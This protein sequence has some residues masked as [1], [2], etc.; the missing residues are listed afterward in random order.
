[1]QHCFPHK[2][3][4]KKLYYEEG[5]KN[6]LTNHELEYTFEPIN[7]LLENKCVTGAH[8]NLAPFIS[9]LVYLDY[10]KEKSSES[11][12]VVA[13]MTSNLRVNKI[14]NTLMKISKNESY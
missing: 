10:L 14:N 3:E 4:F 11:A 8:Y 12:Y 6:G 1:M 5:L 7:E 9:N 2:A 13:D